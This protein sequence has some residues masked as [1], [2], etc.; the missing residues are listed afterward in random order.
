MRFYDDG[1]VAVRADE[2]FFFAD[3]AAAG[4]KEEG[5]WLQAFVSAS[6]CASA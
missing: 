3:L 2:V 4:A 5:F 6:L 1:A